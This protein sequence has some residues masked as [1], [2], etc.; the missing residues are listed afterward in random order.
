MSEVVLANVPME[1]MGEEKELDM[2]FKV[3]LYNKLFKFTIANSNS[4]RFA[5]PRVIVDEMNIRGDTHYLLFYSEESMEIAIFLIPFPDLV[6]YMKFVVAPPRQSSQKRSKAKLGKGEIIYTL[7]ANGILSDAL[8]RVWV[9]KNK[10]GYERYG[11]VIPK[12]IVTAMNI[13]KGT[14]F[15]LLFSV[16]ANIIIIEIRNLLFGSKNTERGL[17]EGPR[18]I[19]VE[20]VGQV[21]E[22]EMEAEI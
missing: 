8:K 1:Y 17:D 15:L 21:E 18:Q 19:K 12:D 16:E 22:D 5:F 9:S 14:R 4:W 20:A 13:S 7:K 3:K 10:S 2:V 6:R 11:I